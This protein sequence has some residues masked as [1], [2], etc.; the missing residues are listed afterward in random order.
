MYQ[1]GDEVAGGD[2]DEVFVGPGNGVGVGGSA[3]EDG[4]LEA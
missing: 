4:G 3:D 2:G 1:N